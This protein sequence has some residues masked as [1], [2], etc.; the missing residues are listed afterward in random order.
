MYIILVFTHLGSMLLKRH[1]MA[2]YLT[3]IE[4]VPQKYRNGSTGMLIKTYYHYFWDTVISQYSTILTQHPW[5]SVNINFLLHNISIYHHPIHCHK[6]HCTV[7]LSGLHYTFTLTAAWCVL[8]HKWLN[9][10]LFLH[11]FSSCLN[12]MHL[13]AKLQDSVTPV[14]DATSNNT[15]YKS[16]IPTWEQSQPAIYKFLPMIQLGGR[17]CIHTIF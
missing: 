5:K 12:T 6:L 16:R 10:I 4:L 14:A 8:F 11:S 7:A 1:Y 15:K 9:H 2:S 17:S 13:P 3:Q